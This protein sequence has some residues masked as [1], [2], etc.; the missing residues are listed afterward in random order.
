MLQEYHATSYTAGVAEVWHYAWMGLAVVA[1][2]S[3]VLTI[4]VYSWQQKY[5]RLHTLTWMAF[6][7][8][9]T[10]PG[11]LAYWSMHRREPLA[12]CP[13]CKREVPRNREA[14]ARCA[15]SFPEPKLSGTEVFA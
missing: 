6:V 15:E 3:V 4:V 12:A 2:L 1:V 11:F 13:S 14:C 8:L 9:T 5:S 7:F 10:L